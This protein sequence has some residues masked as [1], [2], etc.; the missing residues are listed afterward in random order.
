MVSSEGL[1]KRME[2]IWISRSE[3][4]RCVN[5]LRVGPQFGIWKNDDK[6]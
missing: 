2:V 6:E 4:G 5:G 1:E 3:D